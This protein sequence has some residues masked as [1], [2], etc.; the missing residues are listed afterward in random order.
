[1]ARHPDRQRGTGGVANRHYT[2]K[3]DPRPGPQTDRYPT[4]VPNSPCVGPTWC[5]TGENR[6]DAAF[7]DM[8]WPEGVRRG[9]NVYPVN[10][11]WEEYHE[12]TPDISGSRLLAPGDFDACVKAMCTVEN[13]ITRSWHALEAQKQRLSEAINGLLDLSN[14]MV[15][16][17]SGLGSVVDLHPAPRIQSI[18]AAPWSRRDPRG[19]FSPTAFGPNP[20]EFRAVE[21]VQPHPRGNNDRGRGSYRLTRGRHHHPYHRNGEDFR[22]GRERRQRNGNNSLLNT[23]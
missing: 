10:D 14:S 2:R 11:E 8:I 12:N 16:T 13:E 18:Q 6:N 4:R 22:H 3:G 15:A 1:M 7:G 5:R 23:E 21:A 19:I 20:R 17:L 9:L